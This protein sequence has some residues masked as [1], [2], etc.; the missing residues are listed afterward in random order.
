[1]LEKL[2]LDD[3][4]PHV[5]AGWGLRLADRKVE[6]VLE[7]ARRL[8]AAGAGGRPFSL[9]FR[10]PAALAIPQGIQRLEHPVAGAVELF[11]VPLQPDADGSLFEAVFT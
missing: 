10:G 3:F 1:M 8:G 4:T 6:L 9:L 5:G 2:T 7:E 11:L